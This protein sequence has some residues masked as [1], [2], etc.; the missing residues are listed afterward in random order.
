M[1]RRRWGQQGQRHSMLRE[2]CLNRNTKL[3]SLVIV[4]LTMRPKKSGHLIRRPG[5]A[6]VGELMSGAEA[7]LWPSQSYVECT[8]GQ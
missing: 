5:Y 7:P 2:I 3:R 1:R 4:S 8:F 6:H